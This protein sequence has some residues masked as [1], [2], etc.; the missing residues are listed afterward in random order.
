[1]VKRLCMAT[2]IVCAM[3]GG[4]QVH[5]P[6]LSVF[7][8]MPPLSRD[9]GCACREV[10]KMIDQKGFGMVTKP[11]IEATIRDVQ[12]ASIS[13]FRTMD[14]SKVVVQV[15]GLVPSG[16]ME[17][18]DRGFQSDPRALRFRAVVLA[19]VVPF[20]F[21][22]RSLHLQLLLVYSFFNQLN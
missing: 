21:W 18:R 6:R 5:E 13:H 15:C 12:A 20:D 1:M 4:A 2:R 11:D 9:V 22:G 19:C 17:P 16:M 10:F 3:T 7:V 8:S 14:D